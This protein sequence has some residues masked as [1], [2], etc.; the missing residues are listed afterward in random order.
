MIPFLFNLAVTINS[1]DVPGLPKASE[2]DV[3]KAILNIVYFLMGVI[4]VIVIIIAGL[5]YTTSNG[6][7]AQITA[8]KNQILYAIIGIIVILSAFAITNFVIGQF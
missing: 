1:A 5:R 4:A 2:G 6:T 8:A 3:I 7:P